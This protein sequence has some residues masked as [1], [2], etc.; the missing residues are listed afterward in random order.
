MVVFSNL[1]LSYPTSLVHLQP[2]VLKKTFFHGTDCFFVKSL[3]YS[4][5]PRLDGKVLPFLQASAMYLS[6]S[7]E[8]NRPSVIPSSISICYFS[9]NLLSYT[10]SNTH[11]HACSWLLASESL[12]GRDFLSP[13]S[14]RIKHIIKN[15]H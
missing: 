12:M 6:F 9:Q 3:H 10:S 4:K 1:V 11:S 7:C 8:F 5:C 13:A 14:Q 15:D 2:L